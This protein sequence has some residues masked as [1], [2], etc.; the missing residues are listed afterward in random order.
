MLSE[1]NKI[2]NLEQKLDIKK[3]I[4]QFHSD[5]NKCMDIFKFIITNN[6]KYSEN[7]FY[8]PHCARSSRVKLGAK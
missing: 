5:K 3:Q 2:I 7:S 6:I 1:N 8:Y 4:K